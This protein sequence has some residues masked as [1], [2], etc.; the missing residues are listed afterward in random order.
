MPQQ[1]RVL[2]FAPGRP[3]RDDYV[4]V[5]MNEALENL[6]A[7]CDGDIDFYSVMPEG[8]GMV[9]RDDGN[10]VGLP[11][12]RFVNNYSIKGTFVVSKYTQYG[13]RTSMSDEDAAFITKWIEDQQP[14][15]IRY[16]LGSL[17]ALKERVRQELGLDDDTNF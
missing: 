4:G 11:H 8:F 7:I 12:C 9:A 17:S 15:V 3:V 6:R 5:T 2:V 10:L 16:N 1:H 14:Q 13:S